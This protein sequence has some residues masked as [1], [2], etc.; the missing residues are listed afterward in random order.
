LTGIQHTALSRLV[1]S[2]QRQIR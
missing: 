2:H 1:F